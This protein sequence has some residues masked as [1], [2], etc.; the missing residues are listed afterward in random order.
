MPAGLGEDDASYA[1]NARQ[2]TPAQTLVMKDRY[3]RPLKASHPQKVG[4]LAALGAFGRP[5]TRPK[6]RM[7]KWSI[8][9]LIQEVRDEDTK[10]SSIRCLA[11]RPNDR[12]T[13]TNQRSSAARC[14][15][16]RS[17]PLRYRPAR[18]Q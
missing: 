15:L 16:D 2:R 6:G 12:P 18:K 11:S 3:I 4:S 8:I 5:G 1:V 13:S 7:P 10:R 17:R 9:R 14:R